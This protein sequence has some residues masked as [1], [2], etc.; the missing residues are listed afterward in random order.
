MFFGTFTPKLDSKGRF[1]LPAKVRDP[2]MAGA[3]VSMQPDHCLAVWE[4]AV[5]GEEMAK[6]TAGPMTSRKVRDNQR[7]WA[8]MADEQTP[9]AQGRLSIS[10]IQRQYAGLDRDIVVVGAYNHLEIWDANTWNERFNAQLQAFAEMD[11]E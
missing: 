8:S 4:P 1:F 11:E 5:F 9:D 10:A 7:L 3:I 6:A 2:L